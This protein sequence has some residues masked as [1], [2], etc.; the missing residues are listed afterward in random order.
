MRE[1]AAKNLTE[2]ANNWCP[3]MKKTTQRFN[4]KPTPSQRKNLAR[5]M[6]LTSLSVTSGFVSLPGLTV[7]VHRPL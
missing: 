7:D 1:L 3:K 6:S 2:L 4:R 5:R